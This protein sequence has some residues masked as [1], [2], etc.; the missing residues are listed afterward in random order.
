MIEQ[1]TKWISVFLF[2]FSIPALFWMWWCLQ[3]ECV[4]SIEIASHS[5]LFPLFY[6]RCLLQFWPFSSI[7]THTMHILAECYGH[8]PF[9]WNPY[10]Y[11]HNFGWCRTQRST[12][13]HIS[14]HMNAVQLWLNFITDD[15][16]IHGQL[17][18]C[19]W[20]CKI[21]RMCS[22]GHQG[23]YVICTTFP[24]R[25]IINFECMFLDFEFEITTRRESTD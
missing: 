3:H 2:T 4:E 8:F 19:T 22:L 12:L 6:R 10:A 9:T 21:F 16:A 5:S 23:K 7:L 20:C 24:S 15:W 11:C 13:T 1:E 25:A 18:I 17:C 14:I